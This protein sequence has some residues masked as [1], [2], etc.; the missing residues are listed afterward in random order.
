MMKA[1]YM[2]LDV[3]VDHH[4]DLQGSPVP[5]TPL[6]TDGDSTVNSRSAV[7]RRLFGTPTA[8]GNEDI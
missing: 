3:S 4:L 8:Q 6:E 1:L 2:S 7:R 5:V